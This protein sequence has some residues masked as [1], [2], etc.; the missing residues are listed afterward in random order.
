MLN[1]LE[2]TAVLSLSS[3]NLAFI[4]QTSFLLAVAVDGNAKRSSYAV[5]L[6][7]FADFQL[8]LLSN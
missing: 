6:F 7:T 5:A 3:L 1:F 8:S 2:G 4:T